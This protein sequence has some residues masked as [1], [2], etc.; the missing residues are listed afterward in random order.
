MIRWSTVNATESVLGT[1]DFYN[2]SKGITLAVSS[3]D[4][5]QAL[6]A[7]ITR[8]PPY[9]FNVS[10]LSNENLEKGFKKNQTFLHTWKN[11]KTYHWMTRAVMFVN[12]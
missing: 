3:L 10:H 6:N 4:F 7:Q 9:F 5:W 1:Q 8:S 2:I 11:L 12:F